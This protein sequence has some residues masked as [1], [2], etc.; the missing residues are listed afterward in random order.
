MVFA[1]A[2]GYAYSQGVPESVLG[3]LAAAGALVGLLGSVTFPALVRCLDVRHTGIV[4]FGF[5]LACLTLCV[6]S[7][8]APG[9]VF[10]A[11]ALIQVQLLHSVQ[12][13]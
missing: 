7:V 11:S 10:D 5:E 3:G 9:S 6:A 13:E 12:S 2:A 1:F 4:G 8:W